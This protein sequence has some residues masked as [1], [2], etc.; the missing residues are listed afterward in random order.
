MAKKV[1]AIVKLN[2]PAGKA[3]PAPPDR[4]SIGRTRDQYHAI[5]QRI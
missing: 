2:V 5:L 1:K 3:N 4:S